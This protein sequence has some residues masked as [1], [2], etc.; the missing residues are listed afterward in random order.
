MKNILLVLVVI[1]ILSSCQDEPIY[2]E[3]VISPGDCGNARSSDAGRDPCLIFFCSGPGSSCKKG[4]SHI[5]YTRQ[6]FQRFNSE[7]KAGR[8]K[9][10]FEHDSTWQSFFPSYI[11][12]SQ[13]RSAILDDYYDIYIGKDSSIIIYHDTL[14]KNGIVAVWQWNK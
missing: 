9:P 11:V 13:T 5:Q 14:T 6:E 3:Y 1:L 4:T 7:Y 10:Y 12:S 8:V 2:F